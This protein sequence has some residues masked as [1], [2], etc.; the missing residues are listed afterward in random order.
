LS[1]KSFMNSV[2]SIKTL[3][4]IFEKMYGASKASNSVSVILTT[5]IGDLHEEG[6]TITEA[7]ITLKLSKYATDFLEA[8]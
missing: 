5:A 3:Y 8:S 4:D 2:Q 6:L 7:N 1:D